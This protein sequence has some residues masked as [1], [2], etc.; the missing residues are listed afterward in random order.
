MGLRRAQAA[1]AKAPFESTTD[2]RV[3]AVTPPAGRQVVRGLREIG[4]V[5]GVQVRMWWRAK[6]ADTD[7]ENRH[8]T[9]RELE[10]LEI[11]R[12]S[13]IDSRSDKSCNLG[14]LTPVGVRHA[15]LRWR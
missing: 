4:A 2:N 15:W 9:Y 14:E 13:D 1:L 6:M 3:T 11:A 12:G 7:V 5:D 10:Q 8:A